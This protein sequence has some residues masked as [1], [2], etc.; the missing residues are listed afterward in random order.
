MFSLEPPILYFVGEIG[1][2]ILIGPGLRLEWTLFVFAVPHTLMCF[3][4]AALWHWVISTDPTTNSGKTYDKPDDGE[5]YV[6]CEICECYYVGSG[7]GTGSQRKHCGECNA[8][9]VGF[10]HHCYALDKCIGSWNYR[11]FVFLISGYFVQRLGQGTV[12]ALAYYSF[13]AN[14]NVVCSL[15]QIFT[16][17][18]NHHI[19]SF[20]CCGRAS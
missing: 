12:L 7:P 18:P 1:M 9:V 16:I 6:Y 5:Q 15:P 10:D 13:D 3:A 17:S 4:V 2:W 8:C 20:C 19:T 14:V 11:A